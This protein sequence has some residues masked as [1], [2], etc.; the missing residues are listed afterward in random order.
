MS[1]RKPHGP[2]S[3]PGNPMRCVAKTKAGAQCKRWASKGL[4]KCKNHCGLSNAE[5]EKR[6]EEA[7][8]RDRVGK[9]LAKDGIETEG[10][11]FRGLLMEVARSAWVVEVLGQEVTEL[12][13]TFAFSTTVKYGTN[14]GST[15]SDP[16]VHIVL[17]LWNEERDRHARFCKMAIEAG[18]AERLVRLEEEMAMRLMAAQDRALKDAGLTQTQVGK[19]RSAMV[20]NLRLIEGGKQSA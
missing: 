7:V 3:S 9:L 2:V 18:V 17:K 14:A 4:D 6:G 16:H 20:R 19:V 10:D 12:E 8:Q 5:R 1:K 13:S 15:I 11:P